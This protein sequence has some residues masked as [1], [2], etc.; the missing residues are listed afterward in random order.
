MPYRIRV[1][2]GYDA[3]GKQLFQSKTWKPGPS[4]TAKN[5]DKELTRQ[6]II[7]EDEVME[8]LRQ[9]VSE[10]P[11]K[12]RQLADEWLD[13]AERTGEL[14]I[15]SIVRMRACRERTHAFMGETSTSMTQPFFLA[16]FRLRSTV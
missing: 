6:A 16:A 11:V 14:K 7:F 13:L 4:V 8:Q 15:S 12:F 5:L 2:C 3:D 9:G 10:K 1:F